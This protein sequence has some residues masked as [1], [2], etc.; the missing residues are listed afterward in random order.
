MA[1]GMIF[2]VELLVILLY[3]RLGTDVPIFQKLDDL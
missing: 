1:C 2:L 3:F